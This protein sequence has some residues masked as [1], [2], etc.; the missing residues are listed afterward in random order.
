MPSE[1]AAAPREAPVTLY[2]LHALG[3]SADS[4]DRVAAQL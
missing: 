4:F 3:A 1:N 2:M